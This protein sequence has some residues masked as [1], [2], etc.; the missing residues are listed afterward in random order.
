MNLWKLVFS[1][2]RDTQFHCSRA[3]FGRSTSMKKR[4]KNG[5][6]FWTACFLISAHVYLYLWRPSPSKPIQKS[7]S[8]FDAN[9]NNCLM[10][11]WSILD[12]QWKPKPLLN[13]FW[14]LKM[15]PKTPSANW[16][17]PTWKSLRLRGPRDGFRNYVGWIV[18]HCW[19][20][21]WKMFGD[22]VRC[23]LT[24]W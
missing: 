1:Y 3:C 10:D 8:Q 19:C 21:C 17:A 12:L 14:L 20:F 18:S 9:K 24:V 22:V 23:W 2:I 4:F 11:C 6:R 16:D 5:H 15:E 13:G 7:P